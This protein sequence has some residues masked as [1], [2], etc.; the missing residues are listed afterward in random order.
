MKIINKSPCLLGALYKK[1]TQLYFIKFYKDRKVFCRNI[2]NCITFYKKRI[3]LYTL[4][5]LVS[6]YWKIL[7]ILRILMNCKDI[8]NFVEFQDFSI[9]YFLKRIIIIYV[10]FTFRQLSKYFYM[11]TYLG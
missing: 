7:L 5:L 4:H 9:E 3:Y 2:S 1:F 10:P 6:T 8:V 11:I